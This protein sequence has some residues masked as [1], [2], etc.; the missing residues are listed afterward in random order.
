V[1]TRLG[2]IVTILAEAELGG[3]PDKAVI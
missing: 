3:D 2:E 1:Q